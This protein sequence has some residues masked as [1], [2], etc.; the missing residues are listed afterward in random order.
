MMDRQSGKQLRHFGGISVAR[1][2]IAVIALALLS[3][4]AFRGSTVFALPALQANLLQ[5][6]GFEDPYSAGAASGW[7][8]WHEETGKAATCDER[9]SVLPVWSPESNPSLTVEASKSQHIGNEFDTWHGGV[10]QTVAVTA[11]A[12]Y[13]FSFWAIGR[14]SNDN[15]PAPSN[16]E[17][18]LGV[19]AGIDPNGSGLWYDNDV[20]W[21][22][23]G[24]PHDNG[25]QS[26][27]QR[28]V[29]EAVTTGNK[30]TVFASADLAGAGQCRGHLD[31][32]FDKAELV[33]LAP[34]PTNTP[35]PQPTRPPS[36]ATPIPTATIV[37]TLEPTAVPTPT[38]APTGTICAK[39]F[40]DQNGNG[41]ADTGENLMAGVTIIVSD[42]QQILLRSVTTGSSTGACFK[43]LPFGLYQVEQELPA[44]LALTT[45]AAAE[46]ELTDAAVRTLRFGSRSRTIQP[47]SAAD[48]TEEPSAD[49]PTEAAAE[50]EGGRNLKIYAISGLVA[51]FV[52]VLLLGALIYYLLRQNL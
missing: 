21:G 49:A 30:V 7:G 37:P 16:G 47:G 1:S 19:R 46:I 5:N 6:G 24:S 20:V 52:A 50:A 12:R 18:N 9:Y 31:V 28:F 40:S 14:A 11:G 17:V 23:A 42:G 33:A 36:T 48:A 34:P 44:S 41:L 2:L 4:L 43:D 26:T 32:W 10:Y 27:W 51:M 22:A 38:K 35:L 3:I 15:Y 8:R 13:R 39:A 25:S 29:V 45:Q